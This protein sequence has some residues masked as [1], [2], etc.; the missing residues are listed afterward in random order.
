M[1]RPL[2]LAVDAEQNIYVGYNGSVR[3]ITLGGTIVTIAGGGTTLGD[4]GPAT[5][6]NLTDINGIAVDAS[7]A[8]YLADTSHNLIRKITPDGLI[9]TIAGTGV[10]GNDGDGGLATAAQLNAPSNIALDNAGNLYIA[11]TQN[12]RV[13][14]IRPDGT[15]VAFAGTGVAG[16]SGDGSLAVEAQLVNPIGIALNQTGAVYISDAAGVVRAVTP[17]G[18]IHTVAGIGAGPSNEGFS[19]DGD[20]ALNAEFNNPGALVSDST[21]KLYVIDRLNERVRMLQPLSH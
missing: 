12:S 17:D 15:I 11:D 1:I 14:V 2:S 20:A 13:R 9:A 7:G 5:F 8:L 3:R 21:G 6:A 18:L 10:A 19:G 16:A 4:G